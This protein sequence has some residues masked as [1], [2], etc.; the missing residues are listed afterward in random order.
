MKKITAIIVAVILAVLI[1]NVSALPEIGAPYSAPNSHI[2]P[3]YIENAKADTGSPNI[4]TAVLADYRGFDTLGETSVMF[5]AGLI[6][7][8]ILQAGRKKDKEE[9]TKI[10]QNQ[11]NKPI[12]KIK[13]IGEEDD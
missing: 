2:T 8:L 10:A 12:E 1:A 5:I 7:V 4:V 9:A 13:F 11:E 6:T 3:Y